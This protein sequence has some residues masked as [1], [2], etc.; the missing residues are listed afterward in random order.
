M[1]FGLVGQH[2]A[3]LKSQREEMPVC[4]GWQVRTQGFP[5]EFVILFLWS[6]HAGLKSGIRVYP[7]AEGNR[8]GYVGKV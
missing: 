8:H 4:T 5:R 1:D 2:F 7:R 3:A 6:F